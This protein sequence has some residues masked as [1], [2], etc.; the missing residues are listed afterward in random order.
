MCN[1]VS[2]FLYSIL[3]LIFKLNDPT[4]FSSI[5]LLPVMYILLDQRCVQ[6]NNAVEEFNDLFTIVNLGRCELIDVLVVGLELARFE[7]LSGISRQTHG[8]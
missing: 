5:V 2:R 6:P 3:L 8:R 4:R 1:V 7:E